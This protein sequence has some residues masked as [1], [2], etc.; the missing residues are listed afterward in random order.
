V[1]LLIA[2]EDH[3]APYEDLAREL[4]I[5]QSIDLVEGR[6]DQVPSLLAAADVALNPRV[7][8]DGIPLKLLNYMAAA[9]PVVSFAGSAPG[10]RHGETGW[11]VPDRDVDA[12]AEG[13]LTVLAQPSLAEQL[14]SN[15]RRYVQAH[16]SWARTAEQVEDVYRGLLGADSGEPIP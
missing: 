15:A 4:G 11:L 14:G 7:D 1:R 5:R 8:C 2:S 16:H 10:V 13:V 3:F 9:K 6:F 12:F